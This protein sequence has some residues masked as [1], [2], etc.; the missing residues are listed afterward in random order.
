METLSIQCPLIKFT[1]NLSFVMFLPKYCIKPTHFVFPLQFRA[2]EA[3][4]IV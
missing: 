1:G 4:C 3:C 2:K